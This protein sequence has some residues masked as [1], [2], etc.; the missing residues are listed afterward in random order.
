MNKLFSEENKVLDHCLKLERWQGPPHINRVKQYEMMLSF[1]V[2][3][4]IQLI[5]AEEKSDP[6]FWL[7]FPPQHYIV[8]LYWPYSPKGPYKQV[9]E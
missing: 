9:F 6:P 4:L 8:H 1:K 2:S 5:S 3:L 7:K